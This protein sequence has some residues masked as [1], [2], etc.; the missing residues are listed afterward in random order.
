[1]ARQDAGRLLEVGNVAPF[2]V[3]ADDEQAA[4]CPAHC[5]VEKI[6]G[7]LVRRVRWAGSISTGNGLVMRPVVPA[8]SVV[9][10]T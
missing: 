5:D 1:M 9:R 6:S 3:V 8:V 4:L 2:L 10:V 7:P